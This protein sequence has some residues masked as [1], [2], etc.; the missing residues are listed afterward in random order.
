MHGL[1]TC[2]CFCRGVVSFDFVSGQGVSKNA[3]VL[4]NAELDSLLWK[5]CNLSTDLTGPANAVA[6]EATLSAEK[7]TMQLRMLAP[8]LTVN[9][10]QV[11]SAYAV[12]CRHSL[13]RCR[14]CSCMRCQGN[15]RDQT[16][17]QI[18]EN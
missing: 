11:A 9:S 15:S 17:T 18:V 1:I 2:V 5:K 12:Q 8:H 3:A 7:Q 10:T 16:L 14:W 4:S 6:R 13:Q